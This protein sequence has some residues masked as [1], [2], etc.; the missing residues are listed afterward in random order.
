MTR[1]VGAGYELTWGHDGFVGCEG[2]LSEA[3]TGVMATPTA[4]LADRDRGCVR[5]GS[6]RDGAKCARVGS[7]RGSSVL[8]PRYE[9]RSALRVPRLLGRA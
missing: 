9:R 3:A 1:P 4:V 5:V 2:A 6:R 8:P 7:G